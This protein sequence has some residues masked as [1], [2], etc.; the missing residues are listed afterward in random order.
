[1]NKLDFEK[2]RNV[3]DFYLSELPSYAAYDLLRKCS[4]YVDGLKLAQR[5]I[6]WT[7]IENVPN[8]NTRTKT[9]QMAAQV[10]LKSN[11]L[12]G[13]AN[14]EGVIDTLA[15]NY[16]GSNNFS[17]I[18]GHGNFGTRFSPEA[19]AGRYTYVS[20]SPLLQ[21]LFNRFDREIVGNQ[22]FEGDKIE[23]L[24]FVP[25]FPTIFLN[26][27][28]GIS[29]GFKFQINPRNPKDI[30]KYIQAVLNKSAR[31][32]DPD[33][34]I[35]YFKGF[36]GTTKLEV[37]VDP[38]T[39]EKYNEFVNY[40]IID[41]VTGTEL[42]I[43]EIPITYSYEQY[44]KVLDRLIEKGTI[45]DYD[46]QSDPKNDEFKFDVKVH[47][48]FFKKNPDQ[49]DWIKVFGLSKSLPEQLN[50]ID[51]NNKIHEFGSIKEI[52][53]SFI[54][55]RLKYYGIRKKYLIQKYTEELKLNVSR[56]LWCKGIVED[57]IKVRNVKKDDIIK[58]L[59][60]I[61][62]I[63]KQDDSYNYLLN[64]SISSITKE[65]MVDLKEKVGELKNLIIELKATSEKDMWLKDLD[66]FQ[67]YI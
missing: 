28:N 36:K 13:E 64:M 7:M 14:L 67:K 52:M 47:R 33:K 29:T 22:E 57:T 26:P 56:Y 59:D 5:K 60:K 23:P 44:I 20:I 63:I 58:Q 51:E 41:K 6:L 61:E 17:Y 46:D 65:K 30:V 1:M 38:S 43:S 53:D 37:R 32:P 50:C 21:I 18:D 45:V 24:F 2:D 54:E 15:A 62:K 34:F 39:G 9:S 4:S 11:Y 10:A 35:P 48:E 12:H 42:L 16:V 19:A 55:I 49:E 66:E 27:A 3:S 25:I 8:P 31:M 40:G